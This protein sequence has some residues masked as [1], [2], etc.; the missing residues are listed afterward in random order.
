FLKEAGHVIDT[1]MDVFVY[2]NIPNGSG[3]SS[4]ASLDLLIGIIA[5]EL[6]GLELT[7]LDLGKIGK[8]TEN[9]FIG[10]HSGIMD[11]FAIGMGADNRA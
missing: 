5:E 4:S 9:H 2:G 7:R 1:G 6:Y 11:Q 3:L 8:Q 10:V